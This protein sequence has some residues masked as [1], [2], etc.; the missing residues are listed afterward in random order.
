MS[1]H[2]EL[3]NE[4]NKLELSAQKAPGSAAWPD[5][6]A[7]LSQRFENLDEREQGLLRRLEQCQSER[8][9]AE[10]AVEAARH[11][12]GNFLATMSH[13]LRTPLNGILGMCDLILST[14][15]SQQQREYAEVAHRSALLLLGL[16]DEV[17]EFPRLEAGKVVIEP[18][19]FDLR[20]TIE[21]LAD[22]LASRAHEKGL[23]FASLIYR[24]VP[25]RALGDPIRLRQ[26]ILHLASNAIKFTHTGEVLIRT[27]AVEQSGDNFR[28][29]VEV[30]D[31][32]CG[33]PAGERERIFE[34]FT[35]GDESST[36]RFGGIG[37]GLATSR[38]LVKLM[39]GTI[40]VESTPGKG[41]T[42]WFSI[43]MQRVGA[44]PQAKAPSA[45]LV[46][47]RVL[48][49]DHNVANLTSLHHQLSH[50]GLLSLAASDGQKALELLNEAKRRS[51]PFDLVL[52]ELMMPFMN[53]I[54]LGRAIQSDAQ[55]ADVPMIL[56]AS[57]GFEENA[58]EVRAAGF[59]ASLT[60]P[61]QGAHLGEC[62]ANVLDTP[63]NTEP[64]TTPTPASRSSAE[65]PR[66]LVVEDNAVNQKVALNMLRKLGFQADLA[67]DGRE[68]LQ[69]V[70]SAHYD[71]V[72]MDCQMPVMDGFKATQEIRRGEAPGQHLPIIALTAYVGDGARELCLEAGMDDYLTKP[73]NPTELQSA[74]ARW[75][76]RGMPA[77][78]A[79]PPKPVPAPAPPPVEVPVAIAE[80]PV[81][82]PPA[83]IED[84]CLDME[85]IAGLREL[86][87]DGEPD[88]VLELAE[89]FF[90]E[91]PRS[92]QTMHAALSKQD[93]PTVTRAAHTLKG[94]ASNIGARPLAKR[95][96]ALERAAGEG[97]LAEGGQRVFEIEQEFSRVKSA[98]QAIAQGATKE[99]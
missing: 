58:D 59:V 69:A 41:S 6:L 79:A 8:A 68:A 75:L 82:P 86:Q 78:V 3:Q 94:C 47:R 56:L 65:P 97:E 10:T 83:V 9:E 31:T 36:R 98:L 72:L 17:L 32:G 15:L 4:L 33:V 49:V 11:T 84:D 18:T 22:M 34:P 90:D 93:A 55:L 12:K 51:K 13:E 27:K 44:V 60:R 40:G 89:V 92:I 74:L 35:Q 16:V 70:Q 30:T 73:L 57:K 7:S 37:L 64:G 67:P 43:P 52:V 25:D 45:N 66:L 1:L 26:V 63:G 2:L 96:E 62:I 77:S 50:W 71:A 21:G 54:E 99:G 88:I 91:A 19:P 20:A 48:V 61:F 85:A 38:R 24:E 14:D 46:G 87:Q 5:L 80:A 23:E 76:T 53:G 28:L 81:A 95:C 39:N 42:F 29:V